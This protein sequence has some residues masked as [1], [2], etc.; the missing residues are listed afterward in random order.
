MWWHGAGV[1]VVALLVLTWRAPIDL[2][3]FCLFLGYG[4][5]LIWWSRLS[6]DRLESVRLGEV[7]TALRAVKVV[8]WLLVVSALIEAVIGLDFVFDQGRQAPYVIAIAGTLQLLALGWAMA[9]L[10]QSQ[11][12]PQDRPHEPAARPADEDT[13][14]PMSLL[15]APLS[16]S[17]ADDD[18]AH[19]ATVM[20]AFEKLMAERR[21]F[22]DPDLTL[23]RI[24]RRA[25]IPARQI[26]SAIN[27]THGRN[28]SQV[29]N[30]YRIAEARRRLAETQEPI[31]SILLESGFQTKSNFNREFRRITGMSPSD[32]RAQAVNPSGGAKP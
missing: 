23:E 24:A 1:L 32:Y 31:T 28:V 18:K 20:T 9:S 3:L 11:P 4:I 29:V 14:Q 15:D 16:P 2:V 25:G 17:L 6:A 22:L 27:A 12:P 21:L 30:E 10:G 13:V 19:H 5:A 8:G 7:G 26:S